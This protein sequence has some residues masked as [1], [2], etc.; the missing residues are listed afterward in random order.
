[1]W[2]ISGNGKSFT[3]KAMS[4]NAM[5]ILAREGDD[6][7]KPKILICAP[8]GKAASLVGKFLVV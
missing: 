2:F 8:T 5:N 7:T 6:L 4:F 1:M 3:I